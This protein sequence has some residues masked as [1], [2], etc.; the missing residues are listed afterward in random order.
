MKIALMIKD[1]L[2]FCLNKVP[3]KK[4][5]FSLLS[6]ESLIELQVDSGAICSNSVVSAFCWC[7]LTAVAVLHLWS[8]DNIL[9]LK[10]CL[11][12]M[13]EFFLKTKI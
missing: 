9:Q 7:D 13:K 12:R 10:T 5:D 4:L 1:I 3:V 11:G 8:Y 2:L 6:F